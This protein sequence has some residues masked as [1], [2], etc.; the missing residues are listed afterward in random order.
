M[1]DIAN[2]LGV[3]HAILREFGALFDCLMWNASCA[4]SPVAGGAMPIVSV[5]FGIVVRMYYQ[6]HE[7]PHFHAEFGGCRAK[8]TLDGVCIA[9]KLES[10]T[11]NRLVREWSA[12]HADELEENWRR[13]RAECD[14]VDRGDES[15]DLADLL[16]R[17]RG[18]VTDRYRAAVLDADVYVRSLE[19][20]PADAF[21][22]LLR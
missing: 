5:F 15:A 8:F 19:D 17:E 11:A 18:P 10:S 7:P 14:G 2:R 9:G 12:A 3:I 1:A 16:S 22:R 6:D 20:L 21:D 4:L 13:C